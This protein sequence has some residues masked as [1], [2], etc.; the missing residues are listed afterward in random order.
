VEP[1]HLTNSDVRAIAVELKNT[2]GRMRYTPS[3]MSSSILTLTEGG[4]HE[5]FQL[6]SLNTENVL[7]AECHSERTPPHPSGPMGPILDALHS[8]GISG[9]PS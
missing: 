6:N 3:R 9:R 7:E 2:Y 1:S 5:K 4:C 8:Q